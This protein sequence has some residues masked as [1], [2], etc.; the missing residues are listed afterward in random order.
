MCP[1][2]F[3]T[4]T[5]F[6]VS[7]IS[8][9]VTASFVAKTHKEENPMSMS[10]QPHKFASQDEWLKA[11][12]A[13]LKKE[14]ELTQLRD[15]LAKERRELPWV[16]VE[17]E[18]LFDT[19][20]G[21]KSLHDLFQGRSQLIIYHFMLGPGWQEGCVGCSFLADHFDGAV[22]H[23]ENH[24]VSLVVVS[25]ATLPEIDAFKN[26]MKWNFQWVS[27]N[28]SDFNYDYHVSFTQ[29]EINTGK[30][31]YNYETRDF[32]CED[33]FGTSVFYKDTDGSIYH[34]YSSFARGNEQLVGAYH[35]LDMTPK[36]RNETGPTHS[37]I[38]WVRH[39]DKY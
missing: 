13:L 19:A 8:T 26:R 30:V 16:K 5:L 25:R 15:A 37:L 38:D 18:Y 28:N 35:F 24:D 32:E 14:K 34:T 4:L 21:K 27:S 20:E 39:H 6:A 1:L 23:L 10:L 7:A 3:A 2:C 12:K 31:Y 29:D 36:G 22:A 33:L 9:G 11:R 17:K